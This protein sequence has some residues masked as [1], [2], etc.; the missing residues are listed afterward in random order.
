MGGERRY[1][2]DF[3]LARTLDGFQSSLGFSAKL[4]DFALF[5]LLLEEELI[6]FQV[7]FAF[8]GYEWGRCVLLHHLGIICLI[9]FQ[10][11]HSFIKKKKTFDFTWSKIIAVLILTFALS[12]LHSLTCV[13]VRLEQGVFVCGR[14]RGE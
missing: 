3:P 4:R 13:H 5:L 8:L 14:L 1:I 2:W 11:H 10:L 12:P 7:E 6:L 9:S